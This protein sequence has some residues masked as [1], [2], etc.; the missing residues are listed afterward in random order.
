MAQ[1]GCLRISTILG[2]E[3]AML[4]GVALAMA[5]LG[6]WIVTLDLWSSRLL[7]VDARGPGSAGSASKGGA[8]HPDPDGLDE[9][10]RLDDGPGTA[11]RN[12][13]IR[14]STIAPPMSTAV[15]TRRSPSARSTTTTLPSGITSGST[16]TE[17]PGT[18]TAPVDACGQRSGSILRK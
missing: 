4:V 3:V 8:K 10:A 14:R 5:V 17:R 18:S 15:A 16:A 11:P 6:G 1:V 12:R 2:A 13:S 9:A 7:L